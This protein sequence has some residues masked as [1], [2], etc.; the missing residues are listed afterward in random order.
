MVNIFVIFYK[1]I[2]LR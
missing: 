2:L 1:R